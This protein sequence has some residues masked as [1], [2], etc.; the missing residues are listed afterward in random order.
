MTG[1]GAT[2]PLRLPP[3]YRLVAL[4]STGSTMDE[5]RRLAAE[6]A[7]DGTLVWAR[8]QTGGRG[9]LGRPWSSPRG[10][11]YFSLVLRPECPLA[12][13]AEL[14]FIAALAVGEAIGSLAPPMDVTY[15]WPNDVLLNGRKVAG[16]L[17]E[18]RGG[19]ESGLDSLILGCGV[20]ITAF[21]KDAR[22]PATS[23]RF[24]GAPPD[25]TDERMLEAFARYFLSWVNRWLDSGFAPVRTAWIRHAARLGETI[26]VNLPT[27]RLTG[28]FEDLDAE[29]RLLLSTDAGRRRIATGDVFFP[30]G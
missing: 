23:L 6:G 20:N 14:G 7:E 10:N 30:A 22:Y 16:I 8:E 11:L 18:S 28:R 1:S 25:L 21:P 5:A 27:E 3:G 17:L 29:G 4:D 13:A 24:E 9:R 12:R 26:E 15:K 2:A 19:V